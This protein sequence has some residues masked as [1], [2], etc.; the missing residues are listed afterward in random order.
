MSNACQGLFQALGAPPDSTFSTDFVDYT[1]AHLL[2]AYSPARPEAENRHDGNPCTTDEEAHMGLCY[3]KCALL[4]EGAF[5][6][7]TT[8]WWCCQAQPCSFFNSKFVHM[9]LPCEGFDVAGSQEGQG[10][11]HFPGVCMENEELSLGVCYKK[12]ALL[13]RNAFPYRSGAAS[14]CRYN[15]HLACLDALNVSELLVGLRRGRWARR[16]QPGHAVA[17]TWPHSGAHRGGVSAASP[18]LFRRDSVAPPR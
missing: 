13:T 7:R 3:K 5:P 17:G 10:C 16:Q 12:C 15:S 14:C 6:I 9:V 1:A 8:A 18:F 2:D 11:P 4:T